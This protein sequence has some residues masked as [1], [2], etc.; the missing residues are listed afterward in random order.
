MLAMLQT[1]TQGI[2]MAQAP[3][4]GSRTLMVMM[5]YLVGFGLIFWFLILR[6]QRR[7][8]QRHVDM[9]AALKKGDEV[10]TEGGIIGNVV[11]LAED[12]ITIKTAENTRLVVARPKIARVMGQPT[13]E[14]S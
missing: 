4:Q 13:D 6:P 1:E 14:K 5:I 2:L 11:H 3:A 8:Q 9:V 12:R 7:V 10:M